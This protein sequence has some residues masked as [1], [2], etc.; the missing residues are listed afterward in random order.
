MVTKMKSKS[1]GILKA[2]K[3]AW[4][5][6]ADA[7][8]DSIAKSYRDHSLLMIAGATSTLSVTRSK[9]AVL[10]FPTLGLVVAFRTA[11]LASAIAVMAIGSSS[12]AMDGKNLEGNACERFAEHYLHT[13]GKIDQASRRQCNA[14]PLAE[15]AYIRQSLQK[16]MGNDDEKMNHYFFSLLPC[17]DAQYVDPHAP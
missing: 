17:G 5:P 10:F 2:A 9:V 8:G 11:T 4:R 14:E 16:N 6:A 1:R 7:E 3:A 13:N 12:S 15:C